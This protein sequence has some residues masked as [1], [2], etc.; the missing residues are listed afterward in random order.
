MRLG[1]ERLGTSCVGTLHRVRRRRVQHDSRDAYAGY[2]RR[3]HVDEAS[4]FDL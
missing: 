2:A 1:K 3:P 4:R